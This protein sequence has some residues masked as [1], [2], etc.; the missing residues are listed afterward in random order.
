MD[1]DFYAK[2]SI[3]FNVECKTDSNG[4]Q[5]VVIIEAKC[6]LPFYNA[7]VGIEFISCE[8]NAPEG[9]VRLT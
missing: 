8:M 1:G 3:N 6:V 7:T 4:I 9:L 2:C 5:H